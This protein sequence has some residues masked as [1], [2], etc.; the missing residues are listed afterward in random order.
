MVLDEAT[1]QVLRAAQDDQA[2]PLAE[3]TPRQARES[4]AERS[5]N[6]APGPAMDSVREMAAPRAD[7]GEVPIRLLVPSAHPRGVIVYAHGGGWVVGSTEEFDPLGRDLAARTGCAVA[8]VQYRKAPE[9][10]FPAAVE[11]V[12]AATQ[13]IGQRIAEIAFDGAPLLV[14]GDSA[15]GNLSAVVARRARDAGGPRVAAQVLVYPVV[16]TAT[17]TASYRAPENQLVIDLPAMQWCFRHYLPDESTRTHPDA[18][19]LRAESL[20]GLPPAIVVLAEHDVLLDDGLAYAKRLR[21]AGVPVVERTFAGQMHGFF[22]MRGLLPG[23]D[24]AVDFIAAEVD[25][26]LG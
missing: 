14:A 13:R 20:A 7:G 19:P 18:A 21:E 12:W 4:A 1:A 11:D 23:H 9:H 22:G 17:D 25:E 16:D 8:M 5:R 2:P 6:V 3:Q 10:P 15:G 24:D 26:H